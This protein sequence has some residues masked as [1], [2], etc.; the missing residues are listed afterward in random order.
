MMEMETNL[1][2]RGTATV[3]ATAQFSRDGRTAEIRMCLC[4]FYDKRKL[5]INMSKSE[6][7]GIIASLQSLVTS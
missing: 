5:W 6:A 1:N 2:I 7:L 3:E 4:S